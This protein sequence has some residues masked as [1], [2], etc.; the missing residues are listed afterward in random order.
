M[1]GIFRKWEARRRTE[2]V[3]RCL[4]CWKSLKRILAKKK[5]NISAYALRDVDVLDQVRRLR[6]EKS[7]KRT[8]MAA[9]KL[10]RH[11]TRACEG[12][13]RTLHNVGLKTKG[14][15]SWKLLVFT[16]TPA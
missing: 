13:R 3:A 4:G 11:E 7:A 2:L 12:F 6:E 10:F 8:A 15:L 9:W 1:D 5:Y 16:L 14:F